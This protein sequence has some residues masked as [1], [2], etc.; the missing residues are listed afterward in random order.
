M[1]KEKPDM[2]N[3]SRLIYVSENTDNAL[4]TPLTCPPLASFRSCTHI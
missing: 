2:Q 3:L 1:E 4:G